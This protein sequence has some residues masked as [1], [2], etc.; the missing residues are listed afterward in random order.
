MWFPFWYPL[1]ICLHSQIQ[2]IN[3]T[4]KCMVVLDLDFDCL[5]TRKAHVRCLKIHVHLEIIHSFLSTF[6]RKWPHHDCDI[7]YPVSHF[8]EK[9]FS[10]YQSN[11]FDFSLCRAVLVT[12]SHSTKDRVLSTS[13]TFIYKCSFIKT[14]IICMVMFHL[15]SSYCTSMLKFFLRY[16]S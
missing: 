12:S 8:M 15:E 3:V 1:R 16:Q 4:S 6:S 2:Y 13:F 14:T 10:R 11:I 7:L 9:Y 5:C